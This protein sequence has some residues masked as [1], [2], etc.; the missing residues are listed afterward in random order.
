MV[1]HKLYFSDGTRIFYECKNGRIQRFIEYA[2]TPQELEK[3]K[4]MPILKHNIDSKQRKFNAGKYF[5]LD[6]LSQLTYE[7][8]NEQKYQLY[9][10][11]KTLHDKVGKEYD[12][13]VLDKS[14]VETFGKYSKGNKVQC[15]AF[16]STIYLAMLDLEANKDEFPNSPGKK[17]VL[18]SCE[19]VILQNKKPE[20]AAV[21]FER[22]HEDVS[23]DV[24]YFDSNFDSRYE[25]YNGYNGYDDDTIDIAF[26]G[27]PEATWNVD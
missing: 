3:I 20:D 14:F 5:Y 23:D 1:Q 17:M 26:D 6:R 21:M 11:L 22:K 9:E 19:A 8:N 10:D 13:N 2:Y 24:Y 7:L 15:I 18:K 4:K 16:F 25:K 27:H 12:S